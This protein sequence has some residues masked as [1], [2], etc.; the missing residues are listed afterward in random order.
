MINLIIQLF[1]LIIGAIVFTVLFVVGVCYTTIKHIIKLDWSLSKQLTPIVRSITLL[2][3]GLANA[4]AG[5]MLN[6]AY[7]ITGK[8]RFGKWYQTISAVTGLLYLR[9]K[10]IKLRPFL[11]RV[12]GRDH[13]VE[14]I[15]EE[16]RFFYSQKGIN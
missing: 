11:D 10:D 16:D 14:A 13:C 7:G 15:S 4:G 2:F 5:E 9:V 8:I 3:D 6:D 12:L 1:V